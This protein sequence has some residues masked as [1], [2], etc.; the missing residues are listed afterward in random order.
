MSK[1]KELVGVSPVNKS[2]SYQAAIRIDGKKYYLG[3]YSTPQRAFQAYKERKEMSL[4][5]LALKWG[6]LLDPR[7]EKAL[8]N[9]RVEIDD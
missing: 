4:M 6:Y 8:Y 1:G 9:Y 5:K 3:V 2:N 7:A